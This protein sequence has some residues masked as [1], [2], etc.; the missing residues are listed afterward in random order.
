M[1]TETVSMSSYSIERETTSLLGIKA[2]MR[3]CDGFKCPRCEHVNPELG[4]GEA[5]QCP[6]C[7]LYFRLY[8][9]GLRCSDEPIPEHPP[10][11]D[12]LALRRVAERQ[13]DGLGLSAC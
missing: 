10:E 6:E 11:R 12:V 3:V 5:S 7:D 8:G 9:N 4:H 2:T 1:I 13:T